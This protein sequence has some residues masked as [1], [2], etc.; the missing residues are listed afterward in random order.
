MFHLNNSQER[1][2]S[3]EFEASDR[4]FRATEL[5]Q[6]KYY[7][8]SVTAKTRLGWG[9]T[10]YALV[11]TTNN[12]ERPQPPSLPQVSRSQVQSRQIT[13]SWTPGPDGYAP[14]RY[15]T[16]QQSEN[17]G[18][19][20]TI[21][22]R[23]DPSLTSHTVSDLKPFTFYQFR[24]QATNDIG[25]SAWSAES[26][27]VQTLPAAPSR[28]VTGLKVVPIT[29]SSVQVHWDM[30]DA[31]HWS[32]DHETG[33]YRVVY[34]PVSDFPTALQAT[35]KQEVFGINETKMI[36]SDLME[37]RNYEIVVL[38]FNSEGEGPPSPPVTVYVGEAVPTGEP[39][40]V[41]AKPISSTEVH[42]KWKPPQANMQNGKLLGYKVRFSG[43]Q[44]FF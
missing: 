24:I 18:P 23:L 36:L 40:K 7:M 11:L 27:Q 9:K 15:Y 43:H 12:R 20:Q 33:G 38:P 32:G 3:K 1:Q 31:S 10:A 35:P 8:F 39:Q 42:L 13:F 19:F 17:S 34:Q 26:A 44:F 16:V 30:I 22:E 29:T 2:F 41:E 37:D 6:E 21:P 28:G 25:P 14:L 4:T 5:E